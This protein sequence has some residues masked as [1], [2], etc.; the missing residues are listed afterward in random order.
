M[1]RR[2][3]R[4]FDLI[5]C[6][7]L[8]GIAPGC[9][10]GRHLHME[11]RSQDELFHPPGLVQREKAVDGWYNCRSQF[12]LVLI[13]N[14]G[15]EETAAKFT[16]RLQQAG[17]RLEQP[18]SAEDKLEI[19]GKREILL[20]QIPGVPLVYEDLTIWIWSQ[21]REG[22]SVTVAEVKLWGVY[23]TDLPTR[24][25]QLAIYLPCLWMGE[26]LYYIDLLFYGP[27]GFL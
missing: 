12:E 16:S 27:L 3:L 17:W 21:E 20:F 25:A 19:S 15:V 22:K 9:A 24:V 5:L 26:G 11:V 18:E 23:W 1:T 6:L 4:C 7:W 10:A 8:I 2:Y 13:S 14:S